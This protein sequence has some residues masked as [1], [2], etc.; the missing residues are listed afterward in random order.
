[1]RYIYLFCAHWTLLVDM[2]WQTVQKRV[3]KQNERR[4]E[5]STNICI[6]RETYMRGKYST[7]KQCTMLLSLPQSSSKA[8]L[9]FS[10]YSAART[11]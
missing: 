6:T 1:M 3:Y 5:E 9:C 2:I 8:K 4:Q 7:W 11:L 10:K